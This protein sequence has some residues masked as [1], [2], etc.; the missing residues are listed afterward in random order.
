MERHRGSEALFAQLWAAVGG[1]EDAR[2]RVSFTTS[3]TLPCHYPVVDMASASLAA[4]GLACSELVATCY[5]TGPMISVD[6]ELAA[7][8][9]RRP[10]RPLGWSDKDRSFANGPYT[11]ADERWVQFHNNYR[12]HMERH[13]EVLG[14]SGTEQMSD[15]VRAWAADELETAIH[16]AGGAV[17]AS[18]TPEE[19]AEHP[20][21]R[22]VGSE[23]LIDWTVG[24][25]T[26]PR[27]DWQPEATRP[28]AG[29]RVV[30]MTRVIAGP[31]ATM[32]LAGCG[33]EVVRIDPPTFDETGIKHLLLTLGK[34]CAVL[35]ASTEAGRGQLLDL[36]AGADVFVHGLRPGVLDALGLTQEVRDELCPGLVEASFNAYGSTGPWR[37]R[38]G[39]D[40][41]IQL[42]CGIGLECMRRTGSSQPVRLP[43]SVL[44]YSTGYLMAAAAIRGLTERAETGRG[45]R[46]HGALARTATTLA[47]AAEPDEEPI[48]SDLS[49]RVDPTVHVTQFGPARRV[50]FPVAVAGTHLRWDRPDEPLGSS[51]PSWATG[52]RTLSSAITA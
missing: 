51:T 3:G 29:I 45:S 9:C 42:S 30:D 49:D 5:G 11:T 41:L 35:D 33:A 10:L 37:G 16:E 13:F 22:A 19:W 6:R 47:S 46:W 50:P 43:F 21:G 1:S 12:H 26:S 40:S 20:Q 24:N 28:L 39:F 31:V 4:A 7:A 25:E 23:P 32:F 36:L 44:D 2:E 38:R 48:F 18:H 34:R 27:A 17:A 8:W 14:I 15:A 52:V